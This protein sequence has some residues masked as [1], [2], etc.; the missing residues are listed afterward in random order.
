MRKKTIFA[1][2]LKEVS[3]LEL[4]SDI[5]S[6]RFLQN[7]ILAAILSG[8]TCGLV[9]SWVVARRTVFLSG[10]I[11]HASFGGI[12]LAYFAGFNPLVGA[13]LFAVASA[14][15]IEWADRH[16]KIRQDS[17]I[18]ILWSVGMALGIIFIYLTPGYK[19]DIT[20]ILFGNILSVTAPTLAA[21]AVLAILTLVVFGLWLRPIMYVAFDSDF[22]RSQGV[23][24]GL[25]VYSMAILTS[26]AI[27]L[28]IHA[29]GIVLLI[30]LL[31]FPPVICSF[32]TKSFGNT[33]LWS[34]I[35]ATAANLAGLAISYKFN[36]PTGAAT[37][38]VLAVSLIVVKSV[39]LYINRLNRRSTR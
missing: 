21:S 15:G 23:H 5:L 14:L 1:A 11:T 7:A 37:I 20:G 16:G 6:Y 10:G 19:P 35:T 8:I 38:F 24:T 29:V 30:S 18:G 34:A 4:F 12:G 9:G 22:A 31:S 2:C 26:L 32:V 3:Q 25:V 13:A 36:I 28:S 33:A 17:A 39:T 27:V